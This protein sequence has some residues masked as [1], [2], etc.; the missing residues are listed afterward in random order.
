MLPVT[1]VLTDCWKLMF[2]L[3]LLLLLLLIRLLMLATASKM[4]NVMPAN[5]RGTSWRRRNW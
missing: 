5:I 4:V 2:W 3:L 1:T